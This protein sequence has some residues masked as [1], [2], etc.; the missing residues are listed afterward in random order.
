MINNKNVFILNNIINIILKLVL[1]EPRPDNEQRANV[2]GVVN[3]LHIDF[4]K[5]SFKNF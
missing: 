5:F 2:I 1:K 4:D 3:G